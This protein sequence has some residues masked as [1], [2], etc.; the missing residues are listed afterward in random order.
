MPCAN[1][2]RSLGNLFM[3][4][5]GNLIPESAEV[6]FWVA[7]CPETPTRHAHTDCW[8]RSWAG[9]LS[10]G[11]RALASALDVDVCMLIPSVRVLTGPVRT[12]P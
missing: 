5:E 4:G 2:E 3:S 10:S 12:R 6:P 11:D 9:I 8:T 7:F 1:V